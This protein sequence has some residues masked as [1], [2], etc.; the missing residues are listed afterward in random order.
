MAL[1]RDGPARGPIDSAAVARRPPNPFGVNADP[2]SPVVSLSVVPPF[3]V[4]AVVGL[5]PLW[6]L[7]RSQHARER[8]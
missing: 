1:R 6:L 2:E 8:V 5:V 4:L 3:V 7:L